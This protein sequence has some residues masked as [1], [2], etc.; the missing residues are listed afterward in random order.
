M[1]L[2]IYDLLAVVNMVVG[3]ATL[4]AVASTL[5]HFLHAEVCEFNRKTNYTAKMYRKDCGSV[6]GIYKIYF[7]IFMEQSNVCTTV[8]VIKLFFLA[9]K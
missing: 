6:I 8:H 5:G 2:I 9:F 3:S 7:D 1:A 4:G